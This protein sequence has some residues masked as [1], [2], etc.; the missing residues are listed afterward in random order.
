MINLININSIERYND[1]QNFCQCMFDETIKTNN[2]DNMLENIIE[3]FGKK[4]ID[5]IKLSK[6]EEYI[7]NVVNMDMFEKI[8][9]IINPENKCNKKEEIYNI[10][11]NKETMSIVNDGYICI[12]RL[13]L[14]KF[15]FELN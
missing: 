9:S 11:V 14:Y 2:M 6:M 7:I 10:I 13:I 8:I 4:Y 5:L 3:Y 15:Y 1:F 12:C